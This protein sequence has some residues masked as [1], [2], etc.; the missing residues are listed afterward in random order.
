MW[1][2]VGVSKQDRSGKNRVPASARS[3]QASLYSPV[4]SAREPLPAVSVPLENLTKIDA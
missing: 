1:A 2:S 4:G 3:V